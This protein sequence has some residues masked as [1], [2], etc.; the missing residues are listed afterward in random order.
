MRVDCLTGGPSPAISDTRRPSAAVIKNYWRCAKHGTVL[1]QAAE[2][3]DPVVKP[4]RSSRAYPRR[5]RQTRWPRAVKEKISNVLVRASSL[6]S[7]SP[8]SSGPGSW[9]AK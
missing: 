7:H 6:A 1:R 5:H 8:S 2:Q 9:Y 3:T 4:Y